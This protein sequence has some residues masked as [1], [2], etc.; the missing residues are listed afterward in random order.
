MV[1]SLYTND[2]TSREPFV[3]VMQVADNTTVIGLIRDSDK[4]AY[5]LEVDQLALW[6]S[7]KNLE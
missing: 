4:S 1:F 5:G 2:C 7:H 6:C 3:K